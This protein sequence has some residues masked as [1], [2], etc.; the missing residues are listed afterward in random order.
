LIIKHSKHKTMKH[1][2]IIE[3]NEHIRENLREILELEAYHVTSASNGKSGI[4]KALQVK[5]DCI[6]CDISM[7]IK[8]GYEVFKTLKPFLQSNNIPFILL[9]ASA[10]KNEIA[11]G[12]MIGVDDYITKPF[13]TEKLLKTIEKLLNK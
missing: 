2:L 5:P 6:L 4:E 8:T 7:P 13:Q 12:K 10:Q 11:E 9:T 3:D 1:L